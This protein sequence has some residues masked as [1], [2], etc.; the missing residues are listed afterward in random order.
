MKR[1]FLPISMFASLIFTGCS[2]NTE[3]SDMA[4]SNI[5]TGNDTTM[6]DGSNTQD[7]TDANT[8]ATQ[9]MP[10]V[11]FNGVIIM[12]PKKT[13][14][15]TLTMGGSVKDIYVF[16]GDYVKKGQVVA[17]LK[18]PDFILLQQEYLTASAQ[19]EY[20][21]KEYQRQEKLSLQEAASQKKYQ[22]SKA[23][24][25]SMKS[26]LEAAKAQLSLLDV[27]TDELKK[28]GLKTF[29]EIKAPISGYVTSMNIN[30]GSYFGEGDAICQIIDKSEVMLLLTAYEKDL[31]HI[32]TGDTVTFTVNGVEGETFEA[33]I[34]S[35]DQTVN[36][37]NRSIN[38]Y[39]KVKNSNKLFRP[40]MYVN[41][42]LNKNM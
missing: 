4:A 30:I 21:E 33:E 11:S 24:Y 41:A 29:L 12:P 20:L 26:R 37:E 36:T 35:I 40:G 28:G 9:V 13:S 18:N 1:I 8:G 25:M 34:I 19:A 7:S 32:N 23:D 38:V 16:E 42:Q 31:A 10:P 17:T 2:G 27:D 22:Q 3:N 39:A 14:T 15:L 5:A 6:V